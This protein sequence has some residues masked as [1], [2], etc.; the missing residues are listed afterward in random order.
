[1]SRPNTPEPK[2]T[3]DEASQTSPVPEHRAAVSSF[4]AAAEPAAVK[5]EE[6]SEAQLLRELQ[7]KHK[8]TIGIIGLKP[9]DVSQLNKLIL[10]EG[11]RLGLSDDQHFPETI[12]IGISPKDVAKNLENAA[13]ICADFGCDFIGVAARHRDDMELFKPSFQENQLLGVPVFGVTSNLQ[14]LAAR[15][16]KFSIEKAELRRPKLWGFSDE[17]LMQVREEDVEGELSA[18]ERSALTDKLI[19]RNIAQDSRERVRN[20]SARKEYGGYYLIKKAHKGTKIVGIVGGAGPDASA[21]FAE[22]LADSGLPF[23]HLSINS[24]PGKHYF[25]MGQGPSYIPH[26]SAAA[27]QLEELLSRQ[28]ILTIPCNTAHKRLPEYCS[29]AA[30]EKVVDI[31]RSI[32]EKCAHSGKLILLGTNRTVGVGVA[33]GNKGI[34]QELIDVMPDCDQKLIVP[35]P[36]QQKIIMD[37]IYDVKAARNEEAKAKILKVISELRAKHGR[38]PVIL[39]CTELPL[40]FDPMELVKDNLLNPAAAMAELCSAKSHESV[41]SKRGKRKEASAASAGDSPESNSGG[42]RS[43]KSSSDESPSPEPRPSKAL[44]VTARSAAAAHQ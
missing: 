36:E 21:D 2:K 3:I 33:E 14:E 44:K 15:L 25:E 28:L 35:N 1:M 31:R 12:A 37:A 13:M 11:H 9:S 7:L 27:S 18:E 5:V 34:Y 39:G 40:P 29:S 6:K 43:G 17:E 38:L 24:A 10:A 23:I 26:Y 8:G 32:I 30:L 4:A 42:S 22:K 19:E 20:I 41:E 16:V